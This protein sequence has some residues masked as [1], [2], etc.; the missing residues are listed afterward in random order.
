MAFKDPPV[1]TIQALHCNRPDL[2]YVAL[3]GVD[4]GTRAG[5]PDADRA[6]VGL[7]YDECAVQRK[8]DGV[9]SI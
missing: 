1:T 2:I 5:V 9:D 3:E 6:I 7:R 4:G 8:G